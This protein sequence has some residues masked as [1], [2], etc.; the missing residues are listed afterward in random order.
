[1][2]TRR[3]LGVG[4][5][6]V[7]AGSS[8]GITSG[9]VAQNALDHNQQV[10]SGGLNPSRPDFA[11]EVRLRNAIV[12]GNVPGGMSFR[13]NVGYRAP[14]ELETNLGSN[15][16]FAFR[17]DSYYSGLGG[18]GIRGTEALQ[19]QF[20]ATTGNAPPPGYSPILGRSGTGSTAAAVRDPEHLTGAPPSAQPTTPPAP[21]Y[22]PNQDHSAV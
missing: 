2:G 1:M 20:A 13:G 3:F 22:N 15:E 6:L 10:G 18:L 19:Y 12:T 9:A 7:L 11:Q 17:R 21:P 14:G 8:L 16:L 5:L 4:R